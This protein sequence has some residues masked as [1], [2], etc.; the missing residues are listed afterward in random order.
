MFTNSEINELIRC[1]KIVTTKPR[2]DFYY[3]NRQYR[4]ECWARAK[5]GEHRFYIFA[6]YLEKFNEDFSIGLKLE[7]PNIYNKEFILFRCQGPHGA[8]SNDPLSGETHND[9]HVHIVTE[10]DLSKRI[11][12][13]RNKSLTKEYSNFAEAIAFF[14]TYCNVQGGELLIP[15]HMRDQIIGQTI[16]SLTEEDY[17]E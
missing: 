10:E 8:Y 9:Y 7:T 12:E 16:M 1:P 6:R 4:N 3:Q 17:Y 2:R 13:P 5:F 14:I 11:F 15:Q